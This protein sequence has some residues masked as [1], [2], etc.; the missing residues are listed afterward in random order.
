MSK[1][2]AIGGGSLIKETLPI[3]Q[4]IIRLSD[5]KHPHVLFIPTASTDSEEY[6]ATFRK[7]YEEKL[8]A[9]VDLLLLFKNKYTNKELAEKILSADIIYVGGGNT[10]RM[11]KLWRKRGVDKLLLKAYK[12]NIVLSGVSAG[13][14][15]WF[16][17]GH[18][19][20]RSYSN[21]DDWDYI[22]VKGLD[23][24]PFFVCPHVHA[25]GREKSFVAMV[26]MTK[27]PAIGIDNC[28]ALEIVDNKFRVIQSKP[29]AEVFLLTKRGREMA[30]EVLT[31]D[32]YKPIKIIH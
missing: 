28:A 4:E 26:K 6:I 2:V 13:A 27:E 16:A 19:D 22:K 14:I 1:I 5:K 8:Q 17:H 18:S 15:C 9:T 23:L 11:M 32:N 30:K 7:H 29:N 3:D 12:R 25:E 20:S 24:F 21:P 31:N 10:L